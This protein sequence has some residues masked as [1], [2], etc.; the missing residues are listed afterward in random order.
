MNKQWMLSRRALLGGLAASGA[1]ALMPRGFHKV[2]RAQQIPTRVIFV[3]VPEGMWS[4]APK[5][6]AGSTDLGPIFEAVQKWQSR[7]LVVDNMNMESRDHGPGG[8]GHHR[9]VPHMFT[10]TEMRDEGNAGGMSIDQK[11]ANHI[12]G[13]SPFKSIQL[14]DRIV[15]GDTNSTV[16]WSGPGMVVRPEQSPWRAYDR[17]LGGV[18]PGG[19]T[20][21]AE[22]TYSLKKS[23]LDHSLADVAALRSRLTSTDQVL[24]DSYRESLRDIERRLGSMPPVQE[25][26]CVL[27]ELGGEINISAEG[28]YEPIG[29]LHMDIIVAAMQ[30]GQTR[31]ASLQFGNS[32]DQCSYSWLGVNTLGHDMAHNNNNCDP[33]GSKKLRTY[34]WYST[35]LDHLLTKLDG[36]VEGNGTMLDN[37]LVVWA[38][39]FS[40][41]NGHNSNRLMWLLAGN[42]NGYFNMGRVVDAGGKS[43]NDFHTSVQNAFGIADGTFGNPA[44]CDG[45]LAV[46]T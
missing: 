32:N 29:K 38:S 18:T 3:H 41:S 4:G 27:P 43:L 26:G 37:T 14:A 5:P 13:D 1:Y 39:E 42:V 6:G 9:G 19:P 44:Y 45:P 2:A 28:N 36:V 33:S 31:V 20:T 30:C 7:I 46:L 12:G 23:V 25:S 34:Q 11:I 24:L 40:D 10:C 35:M 22:P 17:I 16:I 15:Y 8:D 21:P